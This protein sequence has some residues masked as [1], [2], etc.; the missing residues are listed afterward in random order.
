MIGLV[1]RALSTAARLGL[2]I[3][4]GFSSLIPGLILRALGPALVD[5][6]DFAVRL[7]SH[8]FAVGQREGVQRLVEPILS[9]K[10]P[11]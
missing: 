4:V 6:G 2:F 9:A 1:G 11:A 8:H 10:S 5:V 3:G 7:H